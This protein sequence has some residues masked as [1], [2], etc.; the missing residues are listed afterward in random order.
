[1]AAGRPGGTTGNTQVPQRPKQTDPH[2]AEHIVK[3]HR[4]LN[5]Q[6]DLGLSQLNVLIVIGVKSKLTYFEGMKLKVGMSKT[7][8]WIKVLEPLQTSSQNVP[9]GSD[10]WLREIPEAYSLPPQ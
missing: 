10:T 1:M 3:L 6:T 4:P 2:F 7:L 8:L 9:L 5:W